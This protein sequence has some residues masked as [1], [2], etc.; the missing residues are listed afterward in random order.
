M[1]PYCLTQFILKFIQLYPKFI[2]LK[3]M[4]KIEDPIKVLESDC[5][6]S[7]V[8]FNFISS[9]HCSVLCVCVCDNDMIYKPRAD[10]LWNVRTLNLSDSYFIVRFKLNSFGKNIIQ[11]ILCVSLHHFRR[12]VSV[13]PI[14]GN[15]KFDHQISPL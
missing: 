11:V 1:I 9:H 8:S 10:V 7:L 3:Y 13:C 15:A 14:T 5:H 6:V 2:A 12:H 4:Y